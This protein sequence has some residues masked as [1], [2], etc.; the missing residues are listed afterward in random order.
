MWI[1]GC[2]C[3]PCIFTQAGDKAKDG[4]SSHSKST[5]ASDESGGAPLIMSNKNQRAKDDQHLKVMI[6]A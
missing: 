1:Y 2:T 4:G 5:A 6:C 3:I